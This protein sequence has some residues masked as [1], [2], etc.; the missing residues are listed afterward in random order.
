M[1]RERARR[2]ADRRLQDPA[3]QPPHAGK[4]AASDQGYGQAA[5]HPYHET[6]VTT[7]LDPR[8]TAA[9]SSAT[10]ADRLPAAALAISLDQDQ[11]TKLTI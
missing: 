11:L 2:A 10:R 3:R 8:A 6:C 4:A 1:A 7:E 5:G 9:M